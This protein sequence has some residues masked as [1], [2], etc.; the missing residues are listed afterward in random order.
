M[1][2][3]GFGWITYHGVLKQDLACIRNPAQSEYLSVCVI[4]VIRM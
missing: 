2:G 4:V 1:D 3:S